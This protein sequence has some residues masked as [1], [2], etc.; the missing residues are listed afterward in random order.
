MYLLGVQTF[1]GD[2]ESLESRI[3]AACKAGWCWELNLVPPED[4]E[5]L[6]IAEPVSQAPVLCF[7]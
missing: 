4:Q 2:G 5:V 1:Q 3:T 6:L 7:V